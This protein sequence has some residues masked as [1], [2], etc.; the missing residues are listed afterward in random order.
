[1]AATLTNSGYL[2]AS[3]GPPV[4]WVTDE[5]GAWN[6]EKKPDRVHQLWPV[7]QGR[8]ADIYECGRGDR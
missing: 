2:G 5:L 1:M 6:I 7:A 4:V 8:S 3:D